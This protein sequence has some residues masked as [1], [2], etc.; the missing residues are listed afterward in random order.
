MIDFLKIKD[1]ITVLPLLI[2]YILPGYIFISIKDFILYKKQR[3][4]K[5][6]VL[7]S[8]VISYVIINFEKLVVLCVHKS[9]MDISS[10][11]SIMS[12]FFISIIIGYVY[13]MMSQSDIASCCLKKLNI[14]TSMKSD[15]LTN[16]IDFKLGMWIRVFLNSEQVVYMG[17]I[18]KFE[19]IADSSYHIV[20]SN[21]MLYGYSGEE[22]VN[23]GGLNT[24]WVAISVKDNFRIELMYEP[25]SK[26]IIG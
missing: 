18:R 1:I 26:K 5:N 14:T 20:L 23:N 4:D 13:S 11:K 15:M 3:D 2:I 16:I 21:F 22:F 7:K 19:K 6:I 10:S 24:R 9:N 17:K 12:T 25:A 8:I